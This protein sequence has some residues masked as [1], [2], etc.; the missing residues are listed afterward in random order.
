MAAVVSVAAKNDSAGVSMTSGLGSGFDEDQNE[1]EMFR[2][3]VSNVDDAPMPVPVPVHKMI[4]AP[5]PL[6]AVLS[7]SDPDLKPE[8]ALFVRPRAATA[9]APLQNMI[10]SV[11]VFINDSLID[12]IDFCRFCW[13]VVFFKK[14]IETPTLLSVMRLR[15][16]KITS[17]CE[18]FLFVWV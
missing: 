7:L 4:P 1:N 12:L 9:V 3:L 17:K 13:F 6:I 14:I 10:V 16:L 5:V 11:Y 15:S 2:L 8:A 18:F